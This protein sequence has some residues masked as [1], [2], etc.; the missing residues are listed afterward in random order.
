MNSSSPTLTLI[1]LSFSQT[2]SNSGCK[3]MLGNAFIHFK[4]TIFLSINVSSYFGYSHTYKYVVITKHVWSYQHRMGIPTHIW[5]FPHIWICGNN[6]ICLD[7]TYFCLVS[8]ELQVP[9]Q[10]RPRL[11]KID[12]NRLS[13]NCS[14]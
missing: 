14:I 4:W 12:Q 13:K 2:H 9:N 5:F 10:D 6:Q 3:L 8:L 1:H 7:L 11:T